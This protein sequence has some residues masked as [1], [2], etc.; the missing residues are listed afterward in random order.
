MKPKGSANVQPSASLQ[1]NRA[2]GLPLKVESLSGFVQQVEFTNGDVWV[3]PSAFR[4]E[5]RLSK[6]IPGSLE[7][8]RLSE[9]YRRRGLA[10]LVEELGKQ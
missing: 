2:Q 1:L 4:D 5:A 9:I 8:Q 10:A 7:E 3:T 6:L